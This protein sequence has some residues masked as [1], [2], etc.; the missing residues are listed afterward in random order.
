MLT[1]HLV[2]VSLPSLRQLIVPHIADD[3]LLAAVGKSCPSLQLLDMSGATEVTDSGVAGLYRLEVGGER[4][5]TQL[6]ASLQYLMIGGPGGTLLQP[7]AVCQLLLHACGGLVPQL[8]QLLL[9]PSQYGL[10]TSSY[11]L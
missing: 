2:V 8:V 7:E 6:A 1:K 11:N 5:P 4:W 3:A 10:V 9:V